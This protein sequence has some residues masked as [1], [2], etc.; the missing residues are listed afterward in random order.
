MNKST[1][2]IKNIF[3]MVIFCILLSV[4]IAA[5]QTDNGSLNGAVTDQ[6][7]AVVAGANIT[8]TNLENGQRRQATTNNDGRWTIAVL[9]PGAYE[10][11]VTAPGF[12]EVKQSAA[13]SASSTSAVDVVIGVAAVGEQVTVEGNGSDTIVNGGSGGE[14]SNT[15][16]S[17]RILALP[18]PNR[19]FTVALQTNTSVAGDIAN[20][21]ENGTGSGEV[22]IAGGRPTSVGLLI[23]GIDATSVVGTGSLSENISPAPEFLEEVKLLVGNYDAS[24]GRTGGGNV[25]LITKGGGQTWNGSAWAYF[26]N[27]AFNAN[28]FFFNRDG[29]DRQRARRFEG[30]FSISGPII[31]EKLRFFGGY[32]RTDAETA[33]VPTAQ[34]LSVLPEALAYITDRTPNGIRQGFAIA[35]RNRPTGGWNRPNCIISAPYLPTDLLPNQRGIC[36]NTISPFYR[37]FTQINPVTGD[38]VIPSLR[39]GFERLFANSQNVV[40]V[41]PLNPTLFPNGLPLFDRIVELGL[42]SGNPLVRQRNVV[43]AE[44]QQ[45]QF[46]A[47]LDYDLSKGGAEGKNLNTLSGTFFFSKFPVTDPFSDNTLASPFPLVKD[48]RNLTFAVTDT[49]IFNSSLINEA[50]FGYFF[51]DN[52]RE[53]DERLL[54]SEFTNAGLGIPNPAAV[55]APGGPSSR[56]ARHAGRGN[57]SDFSVCAPNDI[58]NRREQ[59]TLTFA[60]NLTYV[61]EP[62]TFRF[63][64]EYKRNAFDTNL[65]EEQGVEFEKFDNF[66]QLMLGYV[67]EADTAF[68][69]TDKRFRFNDL[70]FYAT[71]EWR[72]GNKLTVSMGLRWDWFGRP[73]EK[74]GQFSNFDPSLLTNPDNLLQ[75]FILPSN[76]GNTGVA[77]TDATLPTLNRSGNKHTLNGQDLNNFAPRVGFRFSPFESGKTI[78]SGGYGIFYDRPSASFINTVYSNY[79]YL[80]EIEESLEVAAPFSRPFNL[81]FS[82]QSASTPFS[83]LLPFRVDFRTQGAPGTPYYLTDST[84]PLGSDNFAEPLE[85]RAVDRDLKTPMV[86]QWN[87]GIQ[88][89]FGKDWVV[90]ARYIGTKGQNLLLAVGFNQPY[91][92]NDPNTPDYIFARLNEAYVRANSPNGPLRSGAGSERLRGCGIAYGGFYTAIAIPGI[93][94]PSGP[95]CPGF[96]GLF[97]YNLDTIGGGSGGFSS[98]DLINSELRVPY[99]GLDQADAVM[100]QSRGYSMY[101]G[102][103]LS[104]SRRLA[105]N[106]G[107]NVSY[108]FSKSIDIGSTDPGSTTASGRPD[109]PNLGLVVQGDQRNINS[110]RAVSDFDRTHRFAGSFVWELPFHRS[111]NKFLNGWQITGFGQ[112]QSGS[113]FSI[114]GTNVEPLVINDTTLFSQGVFLGQF[115]QGGG[116][117]VN[118]P[119]RYIINV[120]RTAGAL[121]NAAFGRPNVVSLALLR[122]RNCSDITRCYFNTNQ[123]SVRVLGTNVLADPEA[124]LL[125][126]YGRFGNLGR[127]ILRGPSQKRIDISVQKSTKLSERMTLEF[128]WDVFNIFN[129]VNFA[130]P[131][132]D[133]TDETDFGQITRT[134]GAPRV[135]QFGVK[136]RF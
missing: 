83:A 3:G 9:K 107:L 24:L 92:L 84:R 56:C 114:L 34:S 33:Y 82:G 136:L 27:E 86:Q 96:D 121:F 39:P 98:I 90:E 102:G 36:I 49:H 73:Y 62:H 94:Y 8:A 25:Q 44:F 113:P 87:L 26:Q 81:L 115:F 61:R 11:M 124:A 99:L 97:D 105:N 65:P 126:T 89:Q 23:N 77:P 48:D 46:T 40:V 57:L 64:V 70:S 131:E 93:P 100:L 101:H 50:R 103:Q 5:Q 132:G 32:Q 35:A 60:N 22:S 88:Q 69:S 79:P 71:D 53:L 13:V 125:P 47:R 127:N 52:T 63:G 66:E 29:I 133:I 38:F 75:G 37:L 45:D 55:F 108:T 20:P 41:D 85:F 59:L 18:L 135:M 122:Q 1:A 6:A 42:G 30:G 91:D 54:T 31:K 28:D 95:T 14:V 118:A 106:Y 130:N 10:I 112:W 78:L 104:V 58:F 68:G 116:G 19:N 123:R 51:L 117:G 15:I 76:A 16:S 120:G 2:F 12:A 43:P 80:R 17:G 67:V 119:R 4:G 109:T 21:L 111:K 7:G 129:L 128:K 134:V 72:V 110:N 74:N